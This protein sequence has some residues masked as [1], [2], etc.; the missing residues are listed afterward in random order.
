MPGALQPRMHMSGI[1]PMDRRQGPPQAVLVGR[2]QDQVDM[3]GHQ[4]P[5]PH[6]DPG[7]RRVLGQQLAIE[8]IVAI[9]EEGP[10]A[11]IAALG[12]VV[13]KAGKDGAGEAGHG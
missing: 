10:R 3:V 5:R 11:A 8:P 2:D 7:R 13:G 6:L 9:T 12:H 1:A 4:H